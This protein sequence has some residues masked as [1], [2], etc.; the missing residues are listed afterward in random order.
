MTI[1]GS[2]IHFLLP[3]NRCRVGGEIDLSPDEVDLSIILMIVHST[4]SN[5]T[6]LNCDSTFFANCW[7]LQ[8]DNDAR[9]YGLYIL[10]L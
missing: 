6:S 2:S 4:S 1:P 7:Q 10:I 3:F 9:V 5:S 8:Y